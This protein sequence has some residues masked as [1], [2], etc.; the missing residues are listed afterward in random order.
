VWGQF[1]DRDDGLKPDLRDTFICRLT[2]LK[3][4]ALWW[5]FPLPLQVAS[6]P[7]SPVLSRP[8]R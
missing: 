1:I 6:A 5:I 7:I 3:L 2:D 8:V 4:D